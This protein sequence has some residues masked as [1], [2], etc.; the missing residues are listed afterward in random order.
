MKRLSPLSLVSLA[1]AEYATTP[2]PN[3]AVAGGLIWSTTVGAPLAWNGSAWIRA[4][5][6]HKTI[7]IENPTNA[8]NISFFFTKHA[9]VLSEIRSILKGSSTPSVTFSIRYGTD[10]SGAGTEVVTSGITVTST[11]TGQVTTSF[12][13]GT[14]PA[15][16]FVWI[17]TSAKSGT[18]TE[19][20]VTLN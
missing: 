3:D 1:I 6:G 5:P 4:V 11:T 10:R 15:N 7:A 9:M 8:E 19:L 14:I 16:N 17:T 13:N 18:V 2:T 12:N 20:A